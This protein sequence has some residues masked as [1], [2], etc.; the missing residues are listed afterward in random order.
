[1]FMGSA[2]L[3]DVTSDGRHDEPEAEP[4][5]FRKKRERK[6]EAGEAGRVRPVSRVRSA[7]APAA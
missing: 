7:R 6:K 5:S 3:G 4:M 2:S 1:M